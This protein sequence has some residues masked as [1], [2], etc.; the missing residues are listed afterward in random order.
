MPTPR[1][2]K[3]SQFFEAPKEGI[4]YPLG[5]SPEEQP[6]FFEDASAAALARE[7]ARPKESYVPAGTGPV[8]DPSVDSTLAP[9]PSGLR[10]RIVI[11]NGGLPAPRPSDINSSIP[12]ASASVKADVSDAV[13]GAI[14]PTTPTQSAPPADGT[15]GEVKPPPVDAGSGGDASERDLYLARLIAQNAA[16]F[17]G[18]GAGKNIDMG[19][20]DTLGERLKQV[21]ALRAKREERAA[22]VAQ[23]QAQYEGANLATLTTQLAAFKD[24]PDIVAALENLKPGAK[25]TK[26][27]DFIKSAYQA[28]TNPPTVAGK[29]ATAKK[30]EAQGD[31]AAATVVAVPEKVTIARGKLAEDIRKNKADE[32][33]RWAALNRAAQNAATKLT[34]GQP[35][36]VQK[37]VR[38]TTQKL[39]DSVAKAYGEIS[40]AL[41]EADRALVAI[42][43]QPPDV[44][45]K[46]M[47]ATNLDGLNTLEERA[48]FRSVGELRRAAQKAQSGLAVTESERAEFLQLFGANWLQSPSSL[49]EAIEWMRRKTK[50]KLDQSF[51]TYRAQGSVGNTAV[52]AYREAG[53]VTPDAQ[54]LLPFNERQPKSAG[55]KAS[56]AGGT[57]KAGAPSGTPTARPTKPADIAGTKTFWRPDKNTWV[58]YAADSEAKARAAG[59]KL[60]E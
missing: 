48:L 15:S 23:E 21:Q 29:E 46:V 54:F 36:N 20:A 38:A 34:T 47:Q 32:V 9:M 24:R 16:G 5:V 53:G 3:L 50:D 45:A 11:P 6:G 10:P 59:I 37:E 56:P 35:E 8:V 22:D 27:S 13:K 14:S 18:M 57:T 43:N 2:R 52:Q 39:G 4:T 1:F 25:Y 17:G 33:I 41:K 60:E 31:V 51:A 28:V 7:N 26:P 40:S 49:I 19:I 42:K 58:H 55:P 44:F 30:T 12:V